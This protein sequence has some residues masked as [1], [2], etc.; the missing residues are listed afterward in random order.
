[1]NASFIKCSH[2]S[3]LY[4]LIIACCN[5]SLTVVWEE[6][7][8]VLVKCQNISSGLISLTAVEYWH[9]KCQTYPVMLFK[10]ELQ[11]VIFHYQYWR[12]IS[13]IT[14]HAIPWMLNFW[15]LSGTS[16]QN[17]IGSIKTWITTLQM[18][19]FMKHSEI[20]LF[21]KWSSHQH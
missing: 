15:S 20:F 1:M 10:S 12:I 8:A 6:K 13:L 17:W 11:E 4:L 9:W 18:P 3:V 5:F 16:R 21:L 7:A 14:F 19:E 2:S